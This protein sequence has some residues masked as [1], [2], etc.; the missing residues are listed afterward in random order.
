MLKAP[1]PARARKSAGSLLL[2]ALLA[3]TTWAAWAAQPATAPKAAKKA[4]ATTEAQPLQRIDTN[5]SVPPP[6][7]PAGEKRSG[8]VELELLVAVD[9]SVKD[10]KVVKSEPAGVFDQASIEAAR[11][12]HVSPSLKDG[13]P[14]ESWIRVPIEFRMDD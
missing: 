6:A 14:I 5:D 9:G 4:A 2:V 8:K 11:K 3:G 10:V 12:W 13:H 7:Y 1:L